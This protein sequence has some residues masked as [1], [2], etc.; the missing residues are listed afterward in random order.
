MQNKKENKIWQIIEENKKNILIVLG[1][2]LSFFIMLGVCYFICEK[3]W[4][5][6]KFIEKLKEQ[7]PLLSPARELYDKSDLIVNVQPL[8]DELNEIGKDPQISIYFEF[9]NTG[10]NISVNKDLTIWPASLMKIPIAMAVAKKVET[11]QWKM[12]SELVLLE[13]DKD[14][15]FGELYKQPVDTRFSIEKREDSFW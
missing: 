4:N 6:G 14:D 11:G 2:I 10:A 8:R 5:E 7:Y 13:S 15:R 9:L 12:D 1:F 3:N